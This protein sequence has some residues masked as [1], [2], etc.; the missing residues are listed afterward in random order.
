MDYS[1]QTEMSRP[2][3]QC[4]LDPRGL[5]APHNNLA[6]L[7]ALFGFQLRYAGMSGTSGLGNEVIVLPAYINGS[8]AAGLTVSLSSASDE[9]YT[10]LDD[11]PPWFQPECPVSVL[12]NTATHPLTGSESFEG[13]DGPGRSC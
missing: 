8:R 2:D 6:E 13:I 1:C 12:G 5:F 10:P 7:L 3:V 9:Q 4:N 11:H